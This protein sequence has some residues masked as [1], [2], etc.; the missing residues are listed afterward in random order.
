MFVRDLDGHTR[1]Y[2][3]KDMVFVRELDGHTCEYQAKDAASVKE[4][5]S[6]LHGVPANELRVIY[7]GR[8]LQSDDSAERGSCA[9][10]LRP[11]LL[12]RRSRL[13]P[14]C[15]DDKSASREL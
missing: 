3:A 6:Q 1:E 8:A 13:V 15:S 5:F 14:T 9:K 10:R 7:G 11:A 2:Q 4:E 12:K